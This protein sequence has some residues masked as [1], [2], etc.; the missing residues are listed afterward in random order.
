MKEITNNRHTCIF[1]NEWNMQ[2]T[3]KIRYDVYPVVSDTKNVRRTT[4]TGASEAMGHNA[5]IVATQGHL[6]IRGVF[7]CAVI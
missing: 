2:R 3:Q 7:A 4:D 1:G 6:H 5:M